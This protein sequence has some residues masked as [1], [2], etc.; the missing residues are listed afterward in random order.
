MKDSCY[1]KRPH[2]RLVAREGYPYIALAA[3]GAVAGFYWAGLLAGLPMVGL[4]LYIVSFFR[5]PHRAIPAGEGSVLSPADGKILEIVEEEEPRYLKARAKRISIFMSPLNCH[6][7]RAPVDGRV[8]DCFY[9]TGS[10]RA[11][12]RPKAIDTNEH[13]AVLLEDSQGRDWL[14]VQIAGWLARRIVSYVDGGEN[15]RQGERFGL[16]QFGS[17]VDLFCPLNTEIL[18]R[19]GEKVKAGLSL[20]AKGAL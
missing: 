10:Y 4:L 8:K 14:V 7:N 1:R 12:F 9:R 19:P 11:A 6:I 17:R 5:N 3:L 2:Q 18:V 13:N 20:L 15:L 16:I